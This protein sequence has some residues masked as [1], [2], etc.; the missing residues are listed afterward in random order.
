MVIFS[1][2]FSAEISFPLSPENTRKSL[3]RDLLRIPL[4]AIVSLRF[5]R[6]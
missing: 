1:L 2:F 3:Q 4:Q 5:A 6:A